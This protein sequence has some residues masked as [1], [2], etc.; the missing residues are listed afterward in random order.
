MSFSARGKAAATAQWAVAIGVSTG[1]PK[2]LATVVSQLPGS[3]PA[4]VLIV[5]H[6]PAA[7][8]ASFAARLDA[9][10]ALRVKLAEPGELLTCGTAYIA[11]GDV[12]LCARASRLSGGAVAFLPTEPAD[13]PHRP[14]VDVMMRSVLSAFG[15]RMVSVLLTGMGCDGAD[16]MVEA[17]KAGAVTIAESADSAVVFGMP[18]EAIRRGG[19]AIIAPAP[20]IAE[21]IVRALPS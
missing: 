17:R 21:E 14:S 7:F 2:T 11:P 6:L 19:A 4:A 16:A 3:L 1:G 20:R 13:V 15:S 10:C 5:Q 9:C 18:K 8:A 12:H